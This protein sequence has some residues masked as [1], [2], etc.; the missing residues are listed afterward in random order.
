MDG[1]VYYAMIHAD[2]QV[3]GEDGRKTFDYKVDTPMTDETGS[4][5]MVVYDNRNV[6]RGN[7]T[8]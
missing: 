8:L 6:P 4:P 3:R 2:K 1:V 7:N 5:L